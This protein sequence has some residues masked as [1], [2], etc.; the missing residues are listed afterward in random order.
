MGF[1]T[2]DRKQIDLIGYSIDDFVEKDSKSRF[3]VEIVDE[4]NIK[5]SLKKIENNKFFKGKT[6]RTKQCKGCSIISYVY[7]VKIK[8]V[9][10]RS[11][12]IIEKYMRR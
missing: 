11:N 4:L 12:E 8:M 10:E 3:I 1:K 7:S 5:E 9:I 2:A 6:Y